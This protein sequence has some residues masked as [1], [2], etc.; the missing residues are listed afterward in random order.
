MDLVLPLDGVQTIGEV[1]DL[2]HAFKLQLSLINLRQN[3]EIGLKLGIVFF[4][5]LVA[6]KGWEKVKQA[7]LVLQYLLEL[8]N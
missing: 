5:N 2:G 1:Y 4:E 7:F 3:L 6:H 8:L